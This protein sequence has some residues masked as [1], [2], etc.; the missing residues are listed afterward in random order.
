MLE[1]DDIV[2]CDSMT[3][4]M[5]GVPPGRMFI[6]NEPTKKSKLLEGRPRVVI[7][8]DLVVNVCMSLIFGTRLACEQMWWRHLPP[9][10]G[11]G[12]APD[13]SVAEMHKVVTKMFRR[14]G[15][16]MT[17]DCSG[18]D[19][20]EEE[21][22]HM[23]ILVMHDQCAVGFTPYAR[24]VTRN[25]LWIMGNYPVVDSAGV[26]FAMVSWKGI[27]GRLTTFSDNSW[28]RAFMS[29]IVK[30]RDGLVSDAR[31]P[32][33]TAGD[34]A[35][36]PFIDCAVEKYASFGVKL[37]DVKVVQPGDSFEFCSNS[38]SRVPIPLN[39][40]KML[41]GV[42][43]QPYRADAWEGVVFALR[44]WPPL[45]HLCH[46]LAR[47]GWPPGKHSGQERDTF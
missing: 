42:L 11:W 45:K 10:A 24:R 41:Y 20:S 33:K 47:C 18:W 19:M 38:I 14:L 28:K 9:S 21:W 46:S 1:C 17:S 34:D 37:T 39:P 27:S 29:C 43:S 44:H 4:F 5:R 6:K 2:G 7:S 30:R 15:A 23:S 31:Y 25:M 40:A 26:L 3:L 22:M 13:E 16:L 32:V 35:V 8:V 12:L 36:E